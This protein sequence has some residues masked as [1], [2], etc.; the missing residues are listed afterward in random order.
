MGDSVIADFTGR[1]VTP[2]MGGNKPV[3][4]RVLLTHDRLVAVSSN[5]KVAI[6]ADRIVH[7]SMNS[8]SGKLERFFSNTITIKYRT[9]KGGRSL[10]IEKEGA[11]AEKFRL[12]LTNLLLRGTTV[13]LYH[14]AR[15]SGRMLEPSPRRAKIS[16]K[17]GK[18]VFSTKKGS[19]S[20]DL[21]SVVHLRYETEETF[22]T[23][24]PSVEWT[25]R[26][27]TRPTTTI[28]AAPD[29]RKLQ[30]LGQYL[31]SDYRDTRGK[32]EKLA[33]ST[34]EENALSAIQ[35]GLEPDSIPNVLPEEAPSTAD[36]IETLGE[37]G[38]VE[39]GKG[40]FRTTILG[41]ITLR[42]R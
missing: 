19:L 30:L 2:R 11:M 28:V 18:A 27:G 20:I 13:V 10:H 38:L 39:R 36:V 34:A 24:Y 12:L 8:I 5:E 35:V 7:V 32:A 31:Q 16:A 42:A 21:S 4:C 40:G 26:N 1:V 15:R 14:P 29:T 22:R 37:K 33:L 9:K 23:S 6:P 41:E 25:Y 3:R 17:R